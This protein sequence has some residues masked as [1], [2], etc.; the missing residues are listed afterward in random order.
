LTPNRLDSESRPLRLLPPAF[1]CAISVI[2]TLV[3]L[4]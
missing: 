1:L 2:S 4:D 3:I